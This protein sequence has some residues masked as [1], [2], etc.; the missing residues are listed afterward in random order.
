MESGRYIVV[1]ASHRDV[2][3]ASETGIGDVAHVRVVEQEWVLADPDR[4][5]DRHPR[6]W[7]ANA[8]QVAPPIAVGQ[9]DKLTPDVIDRER[10]V[11]VAALAGD[12][13]G[14]ANAPRGGAIASVSA[15]YAAEARAAR[16]TCI[17]TWKPEMGHTATVGDSEGPTLTKATTAC[18]GSVRRLP[19]R[20]VRRDG[21]A[22][23]ATGRDRH[24]AARMR[25]PAGL[26]VFG[27]GGAG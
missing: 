18:G 6:L 15:T 4:A 19:L 26:V 16:H 9:I 22:L 23:A 25:H 21:D 10:G 5:Q 27:G 8:E 20:D 1:L 14:A 11:A 13:A 2:L 3:D 17:P 7:Q 24:T 12:T